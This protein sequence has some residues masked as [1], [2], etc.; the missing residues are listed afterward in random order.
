MTTSTS[1]AV[2]ARST[3]H[4]NFPDRCQLLLFFQI[5][6]AACAFAGVA[7]VFNTRLSLCPIR[8]RQLRHFKYFDTYSGRHAADSTSHEVFGRFGIADAP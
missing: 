1:P 2:E 3:K 8:F 4:A 6:H 7:A 5:E